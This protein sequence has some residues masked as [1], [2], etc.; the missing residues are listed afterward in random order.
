MN[1]INESI[2]REEI[3][4]NQSCPNRNKEIMFSL[5]LTAESSQV[6]PS[7]ACTEVLLEPA[8]DHHRVS[9]TCGPHHTCSPAHPQ[10][11]PQLL[12]EATVGTDRQLLGLA[13][14]E[15]NL[16]A[17]SHLSW[18]VRANP[19]DVLR[20]TMT[21]ALYAYWKLTTTLQGSTVSQTRFRDTKLFVQNSLPKCI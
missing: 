9:G 13:A 17:S 16:G 20:W 1:Y 8:L 4:R 10:Q 19:N 5:S 18:T 6:S 11:R 2:N 15:Q 21:G 14:F 7:F 3:W 12:P